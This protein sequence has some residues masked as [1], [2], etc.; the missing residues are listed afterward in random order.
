ME[1]TILNEMTD[2]RLSAYLKENRFDAVYWPALFP[3]DFR[4]E[5][6]WESL[7]ATAGAN[8]KADIISYDSSAPEKGREVIGKASGKIAKTAVKRSMREEDL[9]MYRRLKKGATNSEEKKKI[10]DL[11]FGDVDFVVNAVNSTAEFL[12]LQGL[13]TGQISLDKKNNNG[14]V[15]E[16]A[17]DLGIPKKNKT[18]VSIILNEANLET[19]DFLGEVKKVNKAARIEGVKLN[20]MFMDQD[21]LDLILETKKIKQAY[22]Y[23]LTHTHEE[24]LGTLFLEDL[25]KLLAKNKLPQIVIIDTFLRHEDKD[26]KRQVIQPWHKGYITFMVEKKAG[27]MQHGPIAEEEAESVKK[28]AIQAK[29]GHVLV[30]KF[31]TVDPVVEWTKGEGHFFPVLMNPEDIYILNTNS[32]TK[33]I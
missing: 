25:N 14:L 27:R 22:G 12:S 10:L 33:F 13:S 4:D 9:L 30:T 2:S 26:H 3:L 29:K 15:T 6:T 1:R 31:S 28:H 19:F 24:F 21:T 11:V 8:I 32:T 16:T 23:F 7:S 18:T 5:L 20:F 17:V